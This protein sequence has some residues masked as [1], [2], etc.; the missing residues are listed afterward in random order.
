MEKQEYNP[1][2]DLSPVTK[3]EMFVLDNNSKSKIS[4][5]IL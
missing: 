2:M 3:K 4:A 5:N 1:R